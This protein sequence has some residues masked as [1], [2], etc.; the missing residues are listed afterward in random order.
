MLLP[1][2]PSKLNVA[3]SNQNSTVKLISDGEVNILKQA[4]LSSVDFDIL[5]PNVQYPFAQYESGFVLAGSF[6]EKIAEL[7]T[8]KQPFQFIVTREK[9]SGTG[10][11]NTNMKVS[12]ESYT[13]KEDANNGID[14]VV[15]IKLKQYKEFSTKVCTIE[16]TTATVEQVRESSTSPAPASA[17]SYTVVSGDCLWNIA[18]H[19][20]G[21]GNKYTV[22]Y[23]ANADKIANPNLIYVGQVLTIPAI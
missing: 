7:K 19:F 15:A 8:S 5:L 9:P 4:G 16:N 3:I 14:V 11:F 2:T 10:L 22:I 1:V 20:Y 13:I 23:N 18:K 21:D 17:S 6:L 12:L